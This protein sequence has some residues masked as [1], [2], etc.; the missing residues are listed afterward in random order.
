MLL[1]IDMGNTQTSVG[2][3]EGA[4]LLQHWRFETKVARTSDEYASLLLPLMDRCG[5][6]QSAWSGAVLCSVV[7]PADQA[8]EDFSAQYLNIRVLK[9]RYDMRLD[10]TLNVRTPAEVGADRLANAAYAVK[11]MKLP[12]I[13]V[14]FGTATT[15]DVISKERVYEGGL[16]L[17]GARLSIEALSLKTS[18]N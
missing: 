2:V 10:F 13:V 18:K 4:K 3:Y 14:D 17:P 5:Y 6:S 12:A 8:V 7:P 16:I 9:V 15:F 1:A 11:H